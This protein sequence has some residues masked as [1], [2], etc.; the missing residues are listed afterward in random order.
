MASEFVHF[1]EAARNLKQ[2]SV[3]VETSRQFLTSLTFMP[4]Y[5]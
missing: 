3:Y 1:V 2:S 4:D 5:V